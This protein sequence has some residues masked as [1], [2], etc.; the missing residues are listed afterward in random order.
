MD[1]LSDSQT[2]DIEIGQPTN[3]KARLTLRV[4]PGG[5]FAIG[6]LVAATLVA[7]SK[8]V[9]ESKPNARPYSDAA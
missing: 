6:A 4:T 1:A 2:L 8:L 5:L 9:R 3:R 7:A